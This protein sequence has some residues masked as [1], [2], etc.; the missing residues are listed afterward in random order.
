MGVMERSTRRR[1]M[2]LGGTASLSFLLA[3]CGTGETRTGLY[4]AEQ[5]GAPRWINDTTG[6]PAWSP[7]GA[8]LAWGDERGL[9]IWTK[10]TGDISLIS[11]IPMVGRPTWS[12]DVAAIAFL[13]S[14]SRLLQRVEIA[15]GATTPLATISDGYDGAIRIPVVTRGGPAWSPDGSRVAFICWDGFGDELCV[16]DSS[17]SKRE[18]LTTLGVAEEK[19]GESARSS[20]TSVAWSPDGAA[21]AVALQAERQGATSGIFRVELTARSGR[22][23]TNLTA[24][25]PLAWDGL[26]N[27]VVFSARVEGRSDVYKIPAEGGDA[28]A[29]TRGLADGARE[30]SM[31]SAGKLAVVS[32]R[33]IATLPPGSSEATT[34][35]EPGLAGAAPALSGDGQQLAFLALPRPIEKYP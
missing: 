16:V 8:R 33:Q 5:D 17:G 20:V 6:A 14:Q 1:L 22:R 12:P 2:V 11:A 15:S 25:A 34:H 9:R 29:L 31:D 3:G 26:T 10:A 23:L 19:S 13:D 7:D 28:E 18:Q 24:N 4:I 30:P 27:S 32:G 21:L 35:E